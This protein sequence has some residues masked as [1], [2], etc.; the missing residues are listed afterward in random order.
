MIR[1]LKHH[2]FE[3][4]LKELGLFGLKKRIHQETILWFPVLEESL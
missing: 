3:D 1:G 4:R 2:S